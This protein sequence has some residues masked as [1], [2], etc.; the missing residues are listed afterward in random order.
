MPPGLNAN[1]RGEKRKNAAEWGWVLMILQGKPGPADKSLMDALSNKPIRLTESQ[2]ELLTKALA[3]AAELGAKSRS[4][5]TQVIRRPLG[6]PASP[7]V[8]TPKKHRI[9]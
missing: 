1:R 5:E 8:T 4:A 9:I 6:K 3:E 2:T 7:L